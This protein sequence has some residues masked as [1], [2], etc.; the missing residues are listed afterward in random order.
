MKNL[1]YFVLF[2]SVLT[3]FMFYCQQ[4]QNP[5]EILGIESSSEEGPASLSKVFVVVDSF[6]AV[7]DLEP[8]YENCTTGE[9]MQNHG[10]VRAYLVGRVTPSGNEI[11]NGWVDY[12]A[13]G[14]VTLENLGTGEIWTLTNGHNPFHEIYKENG[15]WVLSYHW[16]ELYKLNNNTLHIQLKGHV[17][18]QPDGTWKIDRESYRCF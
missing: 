18:L 13:L 1:L 11:W 8:P 2:L 4:E 15:F 10:T 7:L 9:D 3:V 14:G 17:K 6:D 5:A 12:D 16:S